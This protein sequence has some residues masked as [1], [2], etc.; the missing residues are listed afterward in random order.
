MRFRDFLD[1][2]VI[3]VIAIDI[4]GTRELLAEG[5][6]IDGRYNNNIRIDLDT[7]FSDAGT[8]NRHAHIYG[9]SDRSEALV[10][11][12]QSGRSSHGK[13]GI[14]HKKDADALHARGFDIPKN[15]IIEWLELPLD[16]DVELLLEQI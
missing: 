6:W 8:D 15:R 1:L 12:R 13:K 11:V 4:D 5:I 2:P 10:A 14:L 3:E 7:H 16:P 9:R